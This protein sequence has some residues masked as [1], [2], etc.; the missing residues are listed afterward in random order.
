MSRPYA[1]GWA[2]AALG[3][4]GAVAH[5]PWWAVA[6]LYVVGTTLVMYSVWRD[7]AW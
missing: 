4:C 1:A 3:G 7:L 2:T 6:M 5:G